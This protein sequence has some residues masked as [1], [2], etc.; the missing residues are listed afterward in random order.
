MRLTT[1][2]A[3]SLTAALLLLAGCQSPPPKSA[4][5][6]I[7]FGH[8]GSLRLDA[9]SIEVVRN[10]R[11]SREPPY[12][13]HLFPQPPDALAERWAKERLLAMGG[14]RRAVV[15]IRDASVQEVPLERTGG[16]RGAFTTD[17]TERYDG[18]IAADIAIFEPDGR[19]SAYAQAEATRSTTV[20]E[21][22]TLAEREQIWF[23]LTEQLMRDFDDEMERQIRG[24]LSSYL[25]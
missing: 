17:Q 11:Q 19:R 4:F 10:D 25:R 8:E 15:T 12:V 7:G 6:Q 24:S 3:A 16:I 5:P 1:A 20:P 9:G 13:G 21:N 14:P 22:A 2:L 23:R 18:R